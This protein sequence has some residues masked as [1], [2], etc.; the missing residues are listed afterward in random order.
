MAPRFEEGFYVSEALLMTTRLDTGLDTV[1]REAQGRIA[2]DLSNSTG[3][4]V[5]RYCNELV[6]WVVY[7]QNK[8]TGAPTDR[9]R[10]AVRAAVNVGL[11][12]VFGDEKSPSIDSGI[13]TRRDVL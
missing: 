1:V 8:P 7:G 10:A 11:K 4:P 9:V 12:Q 3:Q 6:N 5:I 2:T 13:T